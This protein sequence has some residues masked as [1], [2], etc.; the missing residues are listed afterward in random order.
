MHRKEHWISAAL[1][2][3]RSTTYSFDA[4]ASS[5]FAEQGYHVPGWFYA[6]SLFIPKSHE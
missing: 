2:F 6:L 4:F 3:V 5:T 1:F